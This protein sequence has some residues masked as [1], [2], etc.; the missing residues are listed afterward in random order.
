MQEGSRNAL[1]YAGVA[2]VIV[3]GI[4]Y[5]LFY[6]VGTT[7]PAFNQTVSQ[8]ELSQLSSIANNQTL[9]ADIGISAYSGASYGTYFKPLNTTIPLTYNGK[10]ELLYMG[11]EFCPYCAGS[12]WPIILALMR[13]GNLSGIKYS[14][15]SSTDVY[16]STPTFTFYPNY[17][18]SSKYISFR[19]YELETRTGQTLQQPDNLSQSLYYKYASAIPF[20]D[21]MNHSSSEGA[22]ASPG[23]YDGLTWS[24]ITT[25]IADPSTQLSQGVIGAANIYTAE[26]CTAINNTAPVCSAG[27]VKS[28]EKNFIS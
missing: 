10:P 16:A 9:A 5:L 19:A 3:V 6:G 25:Q 1:L 2:A 17:S 12:R 23:L 7:Q 28:T 18:Y 11:A 24:Q 15:S 21:F 26:M 4:G 14:E 8:Q 13:F 27:Y 20:F 22:I